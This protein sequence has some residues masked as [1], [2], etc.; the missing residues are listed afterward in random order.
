MTTKD[1]F[2]E[3]AMA[4]EKDII[5]TALPVADAAKEA[6]RITAMLDEDD[7]ESAGELLSSFPWKS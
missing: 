3:A 7:K 1:L 5:D 2:T 6:A 4:E